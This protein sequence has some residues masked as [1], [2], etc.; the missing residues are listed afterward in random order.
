M[1]LR[2]P[3]SALQPG[4]RA[5]VKVPCGRC[6]CCGF[7]DPGPRARLSLRDRR[8]AE[9]A[10]HERWLE[11]LLQ[12]S[13][14]EMPWRLS[15]LAELSRH[16]SQRQQ[17]RKHCQPNPRAGPKV[18]CQGGAKPAPSPS[19]EEAMQALRSLRAVGAPAL[20][21]A[22]PRPRPLPFP[23]PC[24]N[25]FPIVFLTKPILLNA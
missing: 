19:A 13:L 9:R 22:F 15:L 8:P 17:T 24:A 25:K 1:S 10:L 4:P 5:C 3:L 6:G 7:P 16:G 18:R 14:K 11:P 12:P 2:S 23:L 21:Q 20:W